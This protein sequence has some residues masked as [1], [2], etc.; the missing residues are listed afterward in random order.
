ML[1]R[2]QYS[3]SFSRNTLRTLLNSPY[4]LG[5]SLNPSV[6]KA[7]VQTSK[8]PAAPHYLPASYHPPRLHFRQHHI[9][10]Q[11]PLTAAALL[12]T[13]HLNSA[14]N[15]NTHPSHTTLPTLSPFSYAVRISRRMLLPTNSKDPL[16]IL[17]LSA[18]LIQT[19]G[20]CFKLTSTPRQY[21]RTYAAGFSS[22]CIII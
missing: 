17:S 22:P 13:S 20:T 12:L 9:T 15:Q 3:T 1:V 16:Q 4:V 7:L 19:P 5:A 6:V 14:Q 11:K 10:G 21:I 18:Q 8:L 2:E